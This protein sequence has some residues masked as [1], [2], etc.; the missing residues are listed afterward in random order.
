[1][2]STTPYVLPVAML[3]ALRSLPIDGSWAPGIGAHSEMFN[4]MLDTGTLLIEEEL[5]PT[6][7]DEQTWRIRITKS[8]ISLIMSRYDP[9]AR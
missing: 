2:S 8:G 5:L 7:D 4:E 6:D 9:T 1:M 3:E